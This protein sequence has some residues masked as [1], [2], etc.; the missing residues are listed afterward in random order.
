MKR[1]LRRIALALALAAALPSGA[2][3]G[4]P[5]AAPAP[6]EA[7]GQ[8]VAGHFRLATSSGDIVDSDALAGRPYG[9]FFGFTNCPDICPTTLSDLTLALS[10]LPEAAEPL[11]IYFVSVDPA[12]T[13]ETMTRY[14]AHFDPRI[15]ALGGAP[16]ELRQAIASFGVAVEETKL[17][18]GAS[19]FGHSA[20]V[21]LVDA[22]GLIVDRTDMRDDPATM[23]A[24]LA[25]L[26]GIPAL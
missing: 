21:V 8:L 9:L 25:R 22:D 3:A 7:P 14:A 24:K 12:D 17:S 20:S 11:R 1:A 4:A 6:V 15:V 16:A 19:A 5:E 26:V 23:R 2:L 13:V 18:N 10:G